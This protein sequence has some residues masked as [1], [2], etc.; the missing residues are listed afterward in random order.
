MIKLVLLVLLMMTAGFTGKAGISASAPQFHIPLVAK[1]PQIDGEI[2]QSEWAIAA[3]LSGFV[4]ANGK[5]LDSRMMQ[6]YACY[7]TNNLY[8]AFRLPYYPAEKKPRAAWNQRDSFPP[9]G[10]EEDRIEI[11]LDPNYGKHTVQKGHFMIFFNAAGNIIYDQMWTVA[12]GVQKNWNSKAKIKCRLTDDFWEAEC[13]I[14]LSDL[15]V[16]SI[17]DGERW[18]VQMSRYWGDFDSWTT[19]SPI[20]KVLNSHQHGATM[21]FARD[22]PSYQVILPQP[23]NKVQVKAE[24]LSDSAQKV[25]FTAQLATADKYSASSTKKVNLTPHKKSIVEL[26]TTGKIADDNILMLSLVANGK[27]LYQAGIPFLKNPKLPQITADMR[28]KKFI[29]MCRYLPYFQKAW[30][31]LLDFS[32]LAEAADADTAIFKV[33]MGGRELFKE[34]F[35]LNAQKIENLEIK[36]PG[37]IKD[38]GKY[39]LSL[40]LFKNGKELVKEYI[41]YEYF[42]FP[43][44]GSKAGTSVEIF[45]GFKP[46]EW[47]GNTATMVCSSF[48]LKDDGFFEQ[49]FAKQDEPTVG[50]KIEPLLA[51]PIRLIGNINGKK[52]VLSGNQKLQ[53]EKK[54]PAFLEL[55]ATGYIGGI[56]AKI[57]NNI[58]YDG[59]S[60]IDITLDPDKEI[61]IDKLTLEVAL[62]PARATLMYEITDRRLDFIAG[63][64]DSKYG[65]IWD[66]MRQPNTA[67][68]FGNFKPMVWIG[69]EDMGLTWCAE[70]D[71]F[72]SLDPR[73]PALEL[74]RKKDRVV[75]LVHFVN[76]P[77]KLEKSRTISFGLQPTPSK[78]M[79]ENWRSWLVDANP[80]LPNIKSFRYS[81]TVSHDSEAAIYHAWCSYNPYPPSYD[82]AKENMDEYRNR[83]QIF[84]RYQLI[85]W[86]NFML[87]TPEGR[88]YKGEWERVWMNTYTKSFQDF[89]AYY[90]DQY[91]K[92]VGFFTVYED[93]AYL[94][95]MRDLALDA[96]YL[97]NDGKTQA[98]FGILGLRE[99]LRRCASVWVE[100]D[101]PNM[102]AVHKSGV[103]MTPCHSFAAISIDGEQRFMDNPDRD[104]IDNW[105]LDFIRSHIM[106]R[107]FGVVP[108]FLSEVRVSAKEY[109]TEVVR[110]ANR[111]M[112]ALLL[113]HDIIPWY[114]WN[115]HSPTR[116]MIHRAKSDFNLGDEAVSFHP[117]WATPEYSF[118]QSEND[119]VKV[120]CWKRGKELFIVA[121]NLGED[122][123]SEITFIPRKLGF[124]VAKAVDYETQQ[125]YPINKSSIKVPIPRHDFRII[126]AGE[127]SIPVITGKT[128]AI[129]KIT[130]DSNQEKIKV[131]Q[132]DR[133]EVKDDLLFHAPFDDDLNAQSALGNGNAKLTGTKLLTTG[134]SGK[135]AVIG[136][137]GATSIEYQAENNFLGTD[138]TIVLWVNPINYKNK[139]E[140][141]KGIYHLFYLTLGATENRWGIQI[142]RGKNTMRLLFFSMKFSGR[143]NVFITTDAIDTWKNN[144]WHQVAIAWDE[145][146]IVL[147]VDGLVA[148]RRRLEAPYTVKDFTDKVVKIGYEAT[149][150][151]KEQT[152]VDNLKVFSRRL[153]DDEVR[154]AHRNR[155]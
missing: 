133:P 3:G 85:D 21:V 111:S 138:G 1:A 107:Q 15:D 68:T 135:A 66:S 11:L 86:I 149:L 146:E 69:N 12:E 137:D 124:S 77:L 8:L 26:N 105:P 136:E 52:V 113:L 9:K 33:N 55:S 54:S 140:A 117:Y 115:V 141:E 43:F 125:P 101:M 42:N 119:Q 39:Q 17:K 45:P 34:E 71:R 44:V 35:P 106:G 82:L 102:Y 64:T 123:I 144:Q 96:G 50:R 108:V 81:A 91:L 23:S 126:F 5:H 59:L 88:V 72:W 93:E 60:W 2:K 48:S 22:I 142:Q 61:T 51:A 37:V 67:G 97:R 47:K 19:L 70:S 38:E 145:K 110:K 28:E 80:S 128:T 150:P 104:Y 62:D 100:N 121:S 95:P 46:I 148:G 90:Y 6:V 120:S 56:K 31:D 4:N 65:V 73:K 116:D 114:A 112:L 78:P 25:E 41:E 139:S 76:K 103:T 154:E 24:L 32:G 92:N 151:G 130:I 10:F 13:A 143:K 132:I 79:P 98:E 84:L 57:K 29:F 89:K 74:V 153:T 94:R 87:K 147:Y 16:K 53:T 152:A 27:S 155:D 122:A 83:G 58:E 36:L 99:T 127:S 14:P 20:A 118:C 131:S 134:I 49:I 18:F 40:T 30:I 75:L 109:A 7:D 63:A 129:E